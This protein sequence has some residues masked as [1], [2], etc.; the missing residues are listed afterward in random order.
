[1]NTSKVLYAVLLA[2]LIICCLIWR[3][4]RQIEIRAET[5]GYSQGFEEGYAEGY[6]VG[7]KEGH[8]QAIGQW[9]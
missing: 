8:D 6:R 9:P 7:Y 5:A 2:M 3:S 1:M 4:N